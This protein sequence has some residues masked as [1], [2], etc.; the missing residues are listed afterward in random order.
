MQVPEA[1]TRMLHH[2]RFHCHQICPKSG[3]STNKL[4]ARSSSLSPPLQWVCE[5]CTLGKAPPV[6][7]PK[8]SPA[9]PLGGRR[10]LRTE[11]HSPRPPSSSAQK[12]TGTAVK[13]VSAGRWQLLSVTEPFLLAAPAALGGQC[14]LL[15]WDPVKQGAPQSVAAFC[16]LPS[17]ASLPLRRNGIWREGGKEEREGKGRRRGG[18]RT[19]HPQALSPAGGLWTSQPPTVWLY[20]KDMSSSTNKSSENRASCVL[21]TPGRL[22][23]R[24][25]T[26]AEGWLKRAN[27]KHFQIKGDQGDLSPAELNSTKLLRLKGNNNTGN[28]DLSKGMRNIRDDKNS[29]QILLKF[30]SLPNLFKTPKT[31]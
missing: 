17:F 29:G 5:A 13:G 27:T 7:G 26:G 4:R 21:E 23:G 18:K 28:S 3:V 6:K 24:G 19:G 16:F 12:V 2:A 20:V 22:H 31:V 1:Q 15:G 14:A 8:Q 25:A 11:D 9:S 30:F 10:M